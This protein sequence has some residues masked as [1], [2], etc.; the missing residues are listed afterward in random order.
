MNNDRKL[1]FIAYILSK[2][3]ILIERQSFAQQLFESAVHPRRSAHPNLT[4]VLLSNLLRKE[5]I[6]VFFRLFDRVVFG[7]L[8]RWAV[9]ESEKESEFVTVLQQEKNLVESDFVD[10][11]DSVEWS[12]KLKAE[13]LE[14]FQVQ[15]GILAEDGGSD[16]R[17][18]F[19]Q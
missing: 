1:L 17:L 8:L 19:A 16:L 6:E 11:L 9:A 5:H 10:V 12:H 3:F 2:Y 7:E 14:G 15:N 13:F 18:C 4:Q